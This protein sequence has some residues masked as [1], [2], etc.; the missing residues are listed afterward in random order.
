MNQAIEA[1]HTQKRLQN[2]RH[3]VPFQLEVD[4]QTVEAYPGEMVATVLLSN[5]IRIFGY[6]PDGSPRGYS[7]GIGRCFCCLV[8]IDE[9]PNIRACQTKA[10][11]G[12]KILT[13]TSEEI[14]K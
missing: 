12:M 4:G 13:G 1:V 10:L 9:I 6:A 5:G 2:T 3:G 7:C 14:T 8:T 11:P